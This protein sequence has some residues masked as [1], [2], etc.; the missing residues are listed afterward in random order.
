M[1]LQGDTRNRQRA[2]WD[3]CSLTSARKSCILKITENVHIVLRN[4]AAV[5]CLRDDENLELIFRSERESIMR[6]AIS[7]ALAGA[8]ALN[9]AACGASAAEEA[10]G[11]ASEEAASGK[12]IEAS[13]ED[14][15][16]I[17]FALD[18]EL[19]VWGS[20]EDQELLQTIA[21]NFVEEYSKYGGNITIHVGI[22]SE[23]ECKDAVL[24][25]VKGAADVYAFT[26]DQ[27]EE[28][29][30]AGA[31]QAVSI[32]V[33][34]VKSRNTPASVDAATLDGKLYAY[35]LTADSGY[36]M[37]YDSAFF[38]EEDVQNLD[39]MLEKAAAAGRKVSMDIANGRYLYSF[40]RGAG[41]EA[42]LADGGTTACNWNEEPGADVTQAIMDICANPGFIALTDEGFV[43]KLKDGTL[44]AGVDG[45]WGA[46]DAAGV[47]G[48]G[49]AACKLPT[50]NL[51]GE[52]VQ[53]ASFAS[54]KMIGVNY[55]SENAGAAMIL[56]DYI[57]N[58]ANETLRYQ[59]RGQGPSNI[60]ALAAADSP[61]LNAVVAQSEYADLQ[62]LGGKYWAPAE[63]LG[64]ACVDGNPEGK[65]M[66]QLVD[67]A[68]AGITEKPN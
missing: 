36:F 57:T 24:A 54:F 64:R 15:A 63:A 23:S 11:V 41:L 30:K 56:A 62:R 33:D 32:N 14:A 17:I 34:D 44:V 8:M 10:S 61:A 1:L 38:T 39:T 3:I 31:L 26:D 22:Q 66:Q 20:E 58:E 7:L 5:G 29:V 67:E 45:V 68:V 2:K 16:S 21:D 12:G 59:M 65:T 27:L 35:P 19:T 9:L 13:L 52:Q 4:F 47:W 55:Y 42:T 43:D 60:N 6:K 18:V 40:Y 28:L 50:Y 48:D 25:D 46:D 51:N 53:M 49:Y 37:F